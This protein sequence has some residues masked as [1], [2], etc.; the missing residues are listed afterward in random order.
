MEAELYPYKIFYSGT[1]T[2]WTTI[3]VLIGKL[4]GD[5]AV[6]LKRREVRAAVFSIAY[7]TGDVL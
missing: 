2:K 6:V 7:K 5:R 1:S 3:L 4:V